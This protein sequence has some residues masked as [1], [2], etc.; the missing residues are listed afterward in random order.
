MCFSAEVS[1]TAAA[2]LMPTDAVAIQ[3]A[4]RKDR[5]YLA[6][7]ALPLFFGL[8]QLFEG[9]VWTAANHGSVP[10]SSPLKVGDGQAHGKVLGRNP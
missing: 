2:I 9:L 1:Y 7:A 4:F 3:R 10:T 6:I 5:R 8:Q